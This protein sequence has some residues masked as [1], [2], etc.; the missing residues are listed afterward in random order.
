MKAVLGAIAPALVAAALC[1]VQPAAAQTQKSADSIFH[2][3]APHAILIDA[4]SGS[5]LFE[6]AADELIYPASMSK[7]M[8]LEVVFNEL[9]EGNIKLDTEYFISTDAWKRGGAPSGGSTMFAAIHSKVKVGDLIQG[10]TVQS[11]N[12]ACIALAEG[13]AGNEDGFAR[14]MNGRAHEI[15][16]TK[17]NFVNATGLPDPAHQMTVRELAILARHIIRTYPEYY[18]YFG[19]KEFTWNKIRQLNRNP[20]LKM[21]IGADGMKTGHTKEA[22]YGMVGSATRKGLRLIVVVAGLKSA[23]DRGDEARKLLEVGFRSFDSRLL[24]AEGQYVGEAKLFGGAQ[25]YV[26]LVGK[27]EI[28]IVLPKDSNERLIARIVYTGPVRAPVQKGQEIGKLKV[29]RAKQ[30]AL[31][32]PLQAA[33]SVGTGTTTQ[34]AFDAA[35]ELV[36]SLFRAGIQKL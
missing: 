28:R 29:W 35:V 26:P 19:E 27:D 5:V 30:L 4:A 3:S 36:I 25:R 1:A 12:D 24:F 21:D 20:L 31:E 2:T 22:G 11:A 9:K 10:I 13:L 17:S 34:R 6:K 33:E 23:K 18:H 16:L 7:L 15:G 32:A 14:L 8:T